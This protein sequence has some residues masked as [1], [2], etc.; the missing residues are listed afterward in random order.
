MALLG[1]SARY[2]LPALFLAGGWIH[3]DRA[4]QPSQPLSSSASLHRPSTVKQFV[5]RHCTNCHNQSDKRAG[6][7]LDAISSEEVSAH[8]DVWE[9]V[10]RKLSARQMPPIGRPRPDERT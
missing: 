4:E 3:L 5:T 2:W 8:P 10:V 9:R 7:A 1:T 6:L